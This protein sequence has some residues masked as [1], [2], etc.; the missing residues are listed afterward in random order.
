MQERLDHV[1]AAALLLAEVAH[2]HGDR[3]GSLP[4]DDRI[5]RYHPL[6]PV[7]LG[8]PAGAFS[9]APARL[10]EPNDP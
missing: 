9:E 10:V 4:F 2:A 8:R 7:S 3:G 6:A 5:Q 1:L